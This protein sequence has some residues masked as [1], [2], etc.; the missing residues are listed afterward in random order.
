[1]AGA[2]AAATRTSSEGAAT[3]RMARTGG[4]LASP[5]PE[6]LE[7]DSRVSSSGSGQPVWAN[8]LRLTGGSLPSGGRAGGASEYH[9][10]MPGCAAVHA[11]PHAIANAA[12]R[13]GRGQRVV[14]LAS[15][16]LM[17]KSEYPA[18]GW[19]GW[20]GRGASVAALLAGPCVCGK[21]VTYRPASST[22]APRPDAVPRSPRICPR[23]SPEPPIS[24]ARAAG[25]ASR[26]IEEG[27]RHRR[28]RPEDGRV[29]VDEARA[30]QV[31]GAGREPGRWAVAFSR[32]YTCAGVRAGSAWRS[33]AATAAALGAAAE[34]P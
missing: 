16:F 24:Q 5:A 14:T 6:L 22:S 15:E 33:S 9:Q 12:G 32:A 18:A 2:V 7:A 10:A 31:V 1:M 21:T 19:L 13:V 34:V 23:A 27:W 26:V 20:L 8:W 30:G 25:V 11:Q 28:A 3:A 17:P 29:G 4:L